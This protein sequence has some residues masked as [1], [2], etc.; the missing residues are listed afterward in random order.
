MLEDIYGME[1]CM[2]EGQMFP[3]QQVDF[4]FPEVQLSRGELHFE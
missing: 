4:P 2:G 3:H 1:E